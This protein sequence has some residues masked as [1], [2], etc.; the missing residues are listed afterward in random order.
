MTTILWAFVVGGGF[1]VIA[2]LVLDF[3]AGKITPA[4]VLVGSVIV[5]A[6]LSALG[7]Y[8]P[9]VALAGAGATVPLLG[10]GH[11]MVQGILRDFTIRGWVGLFT[12]GFSAAAIGL[13]SVVIFGFLAALF[14]NPTR[15]Y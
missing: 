5:G 6:I 12:G 3:G 13:S 10:F 9:L 4:H 8:S 15:K 11:T 2:Q 7:L 14:F 1:S